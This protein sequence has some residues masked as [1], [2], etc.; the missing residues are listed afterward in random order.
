MTQKPTKRRGLAGRIASV[1]YRPGTMRVAAM[2][3]RL[4]DIIARIIDRFS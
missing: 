4:I 3:L 1:L 2:V